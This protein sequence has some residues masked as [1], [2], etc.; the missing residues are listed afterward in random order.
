MLAEE[1][2]TID[3]ELFKAKDFMQRKEDKLLPN[4]KLKDF[5]QRY[6]EKN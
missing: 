5:Y 1:E 6:N 2:E 4:R 3:F